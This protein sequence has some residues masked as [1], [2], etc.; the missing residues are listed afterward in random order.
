MDLTQP[1]FVKNKN[2]LVL[3][4]GQSGIAA[5][6]FL[7]HHGAQIT[8]SDIKVESQLKDSLSQIKG[9]YQAS[10]FGRHN[11]KDLSPYDHV[12]VSPGIRDERITKLLEKSSDKIISEVELGLRHYPH[13]IVGIT[14][15]NG[16]TTTGHILKELLS[17]MEIKSFFAG[18]NGVTLCQ[19]LLDHPKK[20]EEVAI[21]E[22]S[23][24]MLQW[25]KDVHPKVGAVLNVSPHHL[26]DHDRDFDNY[27]EAK[28]NLARSL[29]EDSFL[30][31]NALDIHL[32][33]FK[34]AN[35]GQVTY[36]SKH[37][38][39]QLIK[40]NPKTK[41]IHWIEKN[42]L[43]IHM[44]DPKKMTTLNINGYPLIGFHNLDNL[45]AAIQ[46]AIAIDTKRFLEVHSTLDFS[47][48]K[49]PEFR[50]QR[51]FSKE[52]IQIFN[53]AKSTN[54]MSTIRAIESMSA[55]IIL[56]CGG[57]E[58][59]EDYHSMI[60]Y[61]RKKIKNLIL[62]GQTK[63]RLNRILGDYSETYLVGSLEEAVLLAYQK[64]HIGDNILFS[65]GFPSFD[66]FEN[67]IERG[68]AF[69]EALQKI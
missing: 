4:L 67:Y 55:P 35:K 3:G 31:Y 46:I 23:S 52:K 65:P 66:M 34:A 64:S 13:R 38:L 49:A 22:L 59:E 27:L 63:E 14:G 15:T 16:K 20:I 12:V 58:T 29:D 32:P 48:I 26:K 10:E 6:K 62:I 17:Q 8:V 7:H 5:T 41:L 21:I 36:F 25:F 9:L 18:N 11:I 53:D 54:L 30:V 40:D 60:P 56:I 69:N 24:F 68:K 19:Y 43:H 2:V 1:S 37:P 39:L 44:G 61:I 28:I 47:K 33:K 45:M 57:Q 50:L 51:I 42:I